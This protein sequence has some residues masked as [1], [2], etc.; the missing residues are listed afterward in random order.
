M[1]KYISNRFCREETLKQLS[2]AGVEFDEIRFR[3]PNDFRKDHELKAE[4]IKRL[5]SKGHEILED[6]GNSETVVNTLKQLLPTTKI[7]H[8]KAIIKP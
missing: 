6:W 1:L 5:V 2:N 3:R 8:Y 7:I 4:V